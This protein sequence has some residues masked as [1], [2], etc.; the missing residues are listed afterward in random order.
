M[1]TTL[2]PSRAR[3]SYRHEA[4]VWSGRDEY[5]AGLAPFVLE[6]L[7]GGED[8]IVGSTPEHARWLWA[9]L[10]ER[11]TEVRFVDMTR[12]ARN[13]ARIIPVLLALLTECCGPGRPARAIGEP[14][15]PGRGADEVA[16]AE[17]HEALLNLVVDP[18]LPFWLVCPYDADQLPGSVLEAAGS[19]HPVIATPTSYAGS[20]TYRGHDQARALFG[21]DLPE[22]DVPET[23]VWVAGSTLDLAAEQVTLRAAAGDLTSDRVVALSGV[24]RGLVVDSVRR[25][26][27]HARLRV[28]DEPGRLVAE[29][30][31]RTLVKDLLVGRRAPSNGWTD[32]VWT[33]NQVCDLVQVRSN[34]RG[35]SVRLHLDK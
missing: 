31:D 13:P 22:L 33:A 23:D 25:G 26:A 32:P 35:T 12:L 14:L 3:Q 1:T 11:A 6:G 8:V 30:F 10:G 27:D 18:D 16:E 20:G 24:V 19:S 5:V 7:D 4:Y 15:W 28:W 34:P 9:A 2:A 21:T 17:L 29:V